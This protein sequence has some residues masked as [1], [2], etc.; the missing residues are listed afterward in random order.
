MAQPG[1][2]KL[3]I[4]PIRLHP[5]SNIV[6]IPP[7]L[8]HGTGK[9]II[10]WEDIQ[11]SFK[12]P[13]YVM[14]GGNIVEFLM[15]DNHQH[16]LPKR[17]NC[18][19]GVVLDV[20]AESDEQ[21]VATTSTAISSKQPV[22]PVSNAIRELSGAAPPR[23]RVDNESSD[24]F[25]EPTDNILVPAAATHEVVVQERSN[26][27]CDSS[28]SVSKLSPTVPAATTMKVLETDV[29]TD[30]TE[31]KNAKQSSYQLAQFLCSYVD[32]GTPDETIHTD[33][34]RKTLIERFNVLQAGLH[35]DK[36]GLDRMLQAQNHIQDR[37]VLLQNMVQSLI[38]QSYETNE[39]PIPRLFVVLLVPQI[40]EDKTIKPPPKQFRLF[41]LCE[42]GTHTM[43]EESRFPYKIH[44]TEHQGYSLDR[45]D[46]FFEKYG[47]YVLTIMT[48]LKYSVGTDGVA[49]PLLSH[50]AESLD[51]LQK[52]LNL[53]PNESFGLLDETIQY[54]EEQQ[55]SQQQ[56]QRNT[57]SKINTDMEQTNVDV[58]KALNRADLRELGS[59]LDFHDQNLGGAG[60][61]IRTVTTE[62]HIKWFCADHY[63]DN[64]P[65]ANMQQLRDFLTSNH[66]AIWTRSFH[67]RLRSRVPA[68]QFYSALAG[69]RRFRNLNISFRWSVT[70]DDMRELVAAVVKA[71]V[72]DLCIKASSFGAVALD[73]INNGRRYDPILQLMSNGRIQ[74]MDVRGINSFLK[75]ISNSAITTC[76]Q[77]LALRIR[78]ASPTMDRKTRKSLSQLLQNCP[79]LDELQ[80]GGI[81]LY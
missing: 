32:A 48:A 18:Q 66:I 47:S 79:L 58:S 63:R 50:F 26:S 76:S 30:A 4:Q 51:V 45:Q 74:S 20:V 6:T 31:M 16:I 61:L 38:N 2:E 13:Q 10:L 36:T 60:N 59:F 28:S 71:N 8:D 19:S 33:S 1:P 22:T 67:I 17:I 55:R 37:Q 43:T 57:I 14:S 9:H 44:L 72:R 11:A 70:M 42:C 68:K 35:I 62:G 12:N 65:E 21:G 46:E 29:V 27:T 5:T 53:P 81:D 78:V 77:L 56:R 69:T 7:R 75:H 24:A 49:P 54:I 52:L 64:F 15:N 34:V 40:H 3:P 80:I 23:P 25:A 39:C 73:T 41:F